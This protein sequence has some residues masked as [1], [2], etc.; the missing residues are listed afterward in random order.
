MSCRAA[1]ISTLLTGLVTGLAI[2]AIPAAA[3]DN[4]TSRSHLAQTLPAEPSAEDLS[5]EEAAIAWETFV[6]DSGQFQIAMPSQPAVYT[7][8]PGVNPTDS[9]MYMQM[10]LAGT[11]RLEIYAAAFITSADFITSQE[12]IDTALLSCVTSLGEQALQ[13]VPQMLRLGEYQGIEAEF[14][15]DSGLLQIS[16]CYLVGDRAYLLTA[17]SEP[18]DAGS[19]LVPLETAEALSI[20]PGATESGA[21]EAGPVEARP[22]ESGAVDSVES[23]RSPTMEAFFNS[24]EILD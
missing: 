7:F 5:V 13:M 19:G 14:R 22:V 18:F 20:E 8:A 1:L 16:R 21:A 4:L 15:D 24:F 6:S 23:V 12:T 11:D 3:A 9:L 2:T 17:S 10:Q